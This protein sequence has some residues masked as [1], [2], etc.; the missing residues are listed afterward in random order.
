MYY[1]KT[2]EVPEELHAF[3]AVDERPDPRT[4]RDRENKQLKQRL[5]HMK[6]HSG[7][8]GSVEDGARPEGLRYNRSKCE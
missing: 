1:E 8:A 7:R 3:C 4:D 5:R 6:D 2:R